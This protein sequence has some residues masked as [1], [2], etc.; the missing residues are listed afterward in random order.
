[1]QKKKG[2]FLIELA[3]ILPIF[4][5]LLS[6]IFMVGMILHRKQVVTLAARAGAQYAVTPTQRWGEAM[7]T[8]GV[9][10]K[11][12][13][14]GERYQEVMNVVRDVLRRNGLNPDKAT[15]E[16]EW[17]SIPFVLKEEDIKNPGVKGRATVH[18]I[19]TDIFGNDNV[20]TNTVRQ[21]LEQEFDK[22]SAYQYTKYRI[23]SDIWVVKVRVEYPL[24]SSIL[25]LL[26]PIFQAVGFSGNLQEGRVVASC[27][28]PAPMPFVHVVQRTPALRKALF[29][30]QHYFK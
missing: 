14:G 11:L 16:I 24:G 25:N 5:L 30:F 17:F 10:Y 1:M 18:A 28:F 2:T 6:W 27:A 20:H 26:N 21:E 8:F 4:V 12:W 13:S 15:I 22:N 7:A 23:P 9:W 3:I 19:F 29:D